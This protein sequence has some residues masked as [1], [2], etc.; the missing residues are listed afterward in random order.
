MTRSGSGVEP[1]R[2]TPPSG[3]NPATA[4]RR[5]RGRA[6]SSNCPLRP[7]GCVPSRTHTA[8]GAPQ[9]PPGPVQSATA[10]D[11]TCRRD[12][13][14]IDTSRCRRH[15]PSDRPSRTGSARRALFRGA[16]CHPVPSDG[17]DG[18]FCCDLPRDPVSSG[19]GCV[20]NH[21]GKRRAPMAGPACH[22]RSGAGG[23][24]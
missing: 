2:R 5:S 23:G 11:C 10:D 20:R 4:V 18:A 12:H 24:A 1:G 19:I 3:P 15:G 21:F 22:G 13:A 14:R 17:P 6:E 9:D 16:A 8:R 7:T